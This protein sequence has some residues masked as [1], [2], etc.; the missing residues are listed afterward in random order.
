M[1]MKDNLQDLLQ[2]TNGLGVV[3]LIKIIGTDQETKVTAYADDKSVIITGKFNNV[4]P[5][6]V[7]TFGIPNMSK[8]KT[9]ISFEDYNENAVINVVKEQRDGEDQPTTIH[10]ENENADFV[11]DFRLMAKHMV[12]DKVKNVQFKGATWNVTFQPSV[13][14]IQRMKRQASMSDDLTFSTKTDGTD[15]K[16]YFGDASTQSGNFVFQSNVNGSLTKQWKWPVK[17]FLSIMDLP[18]S[19]TVRISDQGAT[20]I[21]VDSGFAAYTYIIPAQP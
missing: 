10:F 12:E 17:V 3:E 18:G 7:G 1:T 21:T 2:H 11:N 4:I 6:F 13:A 8:L 14:N 9:I 15:L 16:V 19:K 5:E 20:E